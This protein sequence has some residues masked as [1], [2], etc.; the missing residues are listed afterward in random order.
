[1]FKKLIRRP[2]LFVF[3]VAILYFLFYLSGFKAKYAIYG[4]MTGKWIQVIDILEKPLGDFSCNYKEDFDSNFQFIPGNQYFY[5][6]DKGKCNYMYPYPYAY[7]VAPF[8]SLHKEYGFILLNL[9]L[10]GLFIF[11]SMASM[12][13]LFPNNNLAVVLAGFSSFFIFPT[14]IYVLDFSE[15]TVSITLGMFGFYL[16]SPYFSQSPPNIRW[17]RVFLGGFIPGFIVGFRTEVI[18]YLMGLVLAI[19]ILGIFENGLKE[20]Q[21]FSFEKLWKAM[22]LPFVLGLGVLLSTGIVFL[23]HQFFFEHFLGIRGRMLSK[24]IMSEYNIVFKLKVIRTL[25]FGGSLGL[26]SSM[27]IIFLSYLILLHKVRNCIGRT[28][29]FLFLFANISSF[30]IIFTSPGHGGYSWSPRYLALCIPFFL[31][32]IILIFLKS[33]ILY[34]KFWKKIILG[35]FI[36]YSLGFTHTGMKIAKNA[37]KQI[38]IYNDYVQ[39]TDADAIILSD[40]FLY[41]MLGK[42]LLN[43]KIYNVGVQR[44]IRVGGRE[45]II[46]QNQIPREPAAKLQIKKMRKLIAILQNQKN[47]RKILLISSLI[48]DK[49]DYDYGYRDRPS[50]K[51]K[52]FLIEY[53]QERPKKFGIKSSKNL[54]NISFTLFEMKQ[55]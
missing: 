53:I 16:I 14:G 1:M 51:D 49:D 23:L 8:V 30:F 47:V 7:L 2:F 27:P 17:I 48:R 22:K 24:W 50:F 43:K 33:P 34:D 44:S 4:D 52:D 28:E 5:E 6:I 39:S 46:G 35:I 54:F 15:M 25:L 13:N 20:N 26:Y 41:G 42:D 3:I 31:F 37:P 12:R 38:K 11:F 55:K 9:L 32:L 45:Y 19:F 10:F 21:Q 18:L 29:F 40:T 36:L